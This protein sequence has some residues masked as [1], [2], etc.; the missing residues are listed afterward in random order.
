MNNEFDVNDMSD[1]IYDIL[2]DYDVVDDEDSLDKEDEG[3]LP[4]CGY[5]GEACG[6]CN[7]C[8]T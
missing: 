3:S 6:C 4:W 7:E 1:P 5:K 2:D 8:L